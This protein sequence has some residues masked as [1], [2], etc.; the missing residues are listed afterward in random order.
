MPKIVS[1]DGVRLRYWD[2][3]LGRSFDVPLKEA[4][5][6]DKY[7][8]DCGVLNAQIT[9]GEPFTMKRRAITVL[10]RFAGNVDHPT[11]LKVKVTL[12]DKRQ[13]LVT[14]WDRPEHFSGWDT[15]LAGKH[16]ESNQAQTV[17]CDIN[18]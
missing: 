8:K 1:I 13:V 14:I 7:W 12:D 2:R 10:K 18:H 9:V 17:A 5:H 16:T 11:T 4:V 6:D 15:L 3:D